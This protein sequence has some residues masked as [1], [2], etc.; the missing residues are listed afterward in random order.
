M[1]AG[2]HVTPSGRLMRP[3][4]DPKI[5]RL[6]SLGVRR[7][8]TG[9]ETPRFTRSSNRS[10]KRNSPL[11]SPRLLDERRRQGVASPPLLPATASLSPEKMCA[12]CDPYGRCECVRW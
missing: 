7:M 11:P 3:P 10:S 6:S 12:P 2:Y 4:L 1:P 5:R 9:Y 8:S